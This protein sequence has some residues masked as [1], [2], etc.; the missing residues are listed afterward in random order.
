MKKVIFNGNTKRERPAYVS[1]SSNFNGQYR[2]QVSYLSCPLNP[3]NQNSE[4]HIGKISSFLHSNV[5]NCHVCTHGNPTI[6]WHLP[7]KILQIELNHL[8]QL[9]GR[10]PAS[11]V[12][13]PIDLCML[14]LLI[15]IASWSYH[16]DCSGH[17]LGLL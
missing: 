13:W 5:A 3:S 6:F 8:I 16:I 14:R 11:V 1:T 10:L 17:C 9:S 12:A 7:K 4:D 2:L 15:N